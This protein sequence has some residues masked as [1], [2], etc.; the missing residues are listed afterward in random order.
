MS[1]ANAP[2]PAAP[3]TAADYQAAALA[4]A[5]PA[6]PKAVEPPAPVESK[7]EAKEGQI[8]AKP[9]SKVEQPPEPAQNWFKKLAQ[10]QK[11]LR[12]KEEALRAEQEKVRAVADL[13]RVVNP[14]LLQRAVTTRDPMV[15]LEAAG[16]S[17]Q[18]VVDAVVKAQPAAKSAAPTESEANEPAYVRDLKEALAATRKEVDELKAGRMEAEASKAHAQAKAIA[19]PLVDEKKFPIISKFKDEAVEE[20]IGELNEF[21][22]QTGKLPADNPQDN[23]TIALARV[24]EKHR[25]LA[26]RYGFLTSAQKAAT[27]PAN[28]APASPRGTAEGQN[29]LT[30][31]MA[32][33]A[34]AV[35]PATPK[36]DQDWQ[37]RA[38]R[39]AG[40]SPNRG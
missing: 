38:M 36:T 19:L 24:E 32:P 15:L 13:S 8:E 37:A 28:E 1:E 14:E 31:F 20:A 34:T 6:A 2:A 7:V 10:E 23:L 33:G 26:E 39:L 25:K 5:K 3:K 29:T 18:D 35:E 21:Y 4:A 27:V 16:M 12:E 22:R 17:Y 11:A 9:E 40:R 30:S